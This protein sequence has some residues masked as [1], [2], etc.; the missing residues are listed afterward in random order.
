MH[1]NALPLSGSPAGNVPRFQYQGV[2]RVSHAAT[3]YIIWDLSPYLRI[4]NCGE[5]GITKPYFDLVNLGGT[6]SLYLKP[7]TYHERL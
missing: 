4:S 6:P 2:R 3:I 1:G 7:T 5:A